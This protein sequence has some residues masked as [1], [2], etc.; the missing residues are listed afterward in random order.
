MP[1]LPPTCDAEECGTLSTL[2]G[3]HRRRI[4][5]AINHPSGLSFPKKMSDGVQKKELS[6][7][8]IL[9]FIHP[10]TIHPTTERQPDSVL[11]YSEGIVEETMEVP[12]ITNGGIS[13]NV[14]GRV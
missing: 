3:M 7:R 11:Y 6:L 10:T 13:G 12:Y 2:Q 1:Y 14:P 4:F 5:G 8:T 9:P